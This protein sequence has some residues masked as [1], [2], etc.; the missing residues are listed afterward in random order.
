LPGSPED[1]PRDRFWGRFAA[2]IQV[3]RAL[4]R[5]PQ[6]RPRP[7]H[8]S[9]SERIRQCSESVALL[10]KQS[11]ETQHLEHLRK[12]NIVV[13]ASVNCRFEIADCRFEAQEFNLKSNI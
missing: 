10:S 6:R 3:R 9:G 8:R 11:I 2:Q 5:L 12:Q 4:P 13:P 1:G 7:G